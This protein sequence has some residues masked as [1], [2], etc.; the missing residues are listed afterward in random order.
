MER[1][2]D[3]WE[4][5][6]AP[7][8]FVGYDKGSAL[9]TLLESASVQNKANSAEDVSASALVVMDEFEKCYQSVQ[10]SLLNLFE[11]G[12]YV[13]SKSRKTYNCKKVVF[14]L[15]SNALDDFIINYSEKHPDVVSHA[16][17]EESLDGWFTAFQRDVNVGKIFLGFMKFFIFRFS[18]TCKS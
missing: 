13:D 17:K 6:G 12:E 7:A 15:T 4:I 5:F 10:I 2:R 18:G 3:V 9:G 14:I 1:I 8:G 16:L 11:S